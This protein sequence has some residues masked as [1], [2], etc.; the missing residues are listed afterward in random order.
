MTG[1][2]QQAVAATA[3]SK[4]LGFARQAFVTPDSYERGRFGYP[5]EAVRCLTGE[6]GIDADSHVV[7]LAAGTGKLTRLLADIGA[8]V[9]AVEPVAEMRAYLAGIDGVTSIGGIAEALPLR[10]ECADAIA[11]AQA[12]HWFT[13]EVA[14]PEIHRVLRAG[15]YLGLLWNQADLSVPWVARVAALRSTAPTSGH[16]EELLRTAK[17]GASALASEVRKRIDR[18]QGVPAAA[19]PSWLVKTR[20][21]FALPVAATL[22]TPLQRRTFAHTEEMDGDRLVDWARSFSNFSRLSA[23]QQ[24]HIAFRVRELAVRELP[25][26]FPFPY[27]TEVFW[28]RRKETSTL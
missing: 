8:A 10:R 16:V 18:R 17:Q 28:C 7:D 26:Q 21:A 22:F 5:T 11:V 14:L 2:P 27:R 1:R 13:P 25:G 12:F 9:T 15:G 3:R 19:D 6:L 24:D 4:D 23:T 20:E